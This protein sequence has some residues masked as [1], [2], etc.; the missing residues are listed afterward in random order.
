QLAVHDPAL[1]GAVF[2]GVPDVAVAGDDGI[3]LL[4][5]FRGRL[6]EF[7]PARAD[8]V[9]DGL[10][11]IRAEHI[12]RDRAA[13]DQRAAGGLIAEGPQLAFLGADVHGA[14]ADARFLNPAVGQAEP[15]IVSRI[16]GPLSLRVDQD[17]GR[18]SRKHVGRVY[19]N[20]R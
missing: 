18:N 15:A 13:I 4:P 17:E 16:A 3:A 2:D 1:V 7:V 11:I 14:F 6:E 12:F 5:Q 20:R 8:F 10:R 19:Y 9:L